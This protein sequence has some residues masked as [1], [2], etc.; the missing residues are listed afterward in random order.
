MNQAKFR[1]SII[2]SLLLLSFLIQGIWFI[3]NA[4]P[5]ADEPPHIASGWSYF[6]FWDFRMNPEHPPLI[7]YWCALPL[8]LMDLKCEKDDSWEKSQEWEFGHK[9]IFNWN[10]DKPILFYSRL[11][12]LI[13]GVFCGLLLWIFAKAVAGEKVAL[14]TLA[15]FSFNPEIISHSSFVTTDLGN[16][17]FYLLTFYGLFLILKK[18]NIKSVLI[19]IAG[20]TGGNI[21]KHSFVMVIPLIALWWLVAGYKMGK[22]HLKKAV[23]LLFITGLAV[24]LMVWVSYG[25]KYKSIPEGVEY[26]VRWE[27]FTLKGLPG[28]FINLARQTKISPEAYIYGWNDVLKKGDRPTFIWGKTHPGGVW[29][30]FPSTFILKTPLSLLILLII[31]LIFNTKKFWSQSISFQKLSGIF[32]KS[33]NKSEQKNHNELNN[34]K[35]IV[36]IPPIIWL[37]PLYYIIFFILFVRLNLGNRHILPIYPFVFIIASIGLIN[38]IKFRAGKLIGAGVFIFYFMATLNVSPNY[39]SFVNLIGGGHKNGWKD[40]ADSNYDWG[41]DLR[42]LKKWS[43]ANGNPEIKLSYFGNDDPTEIGLNYI[44]I[45]SIKPY[46]FSPLRIEE[47]I[48]KIYLKG[49]FAIS[50]N[51][52]VGMFL[53]EHHLGFNPYEYFKEKKPVAL[54]GDSIR[55][56]KEDNPTSLTLVDACM[57]SFRDRIKRNPDDGEAY[58]ML[59]ATMIYKGFE[60]D[61]VIKALFDSIEKDPKNLYNMIVLAKIFDSAGNHNLAIDLYNKLLMLEPNN[62]FA[63][64][65]LGNIYL[66]GKK[67][68]EAIKCFQKSV[69]IV[70]EYYPAWN[71]LALSAIGKQDWNLAKFAIDNAYKIEPGYYLV[72]NLY[73]QYYYGLKDYKSA[74]RYFKSVCNKNPDFALGYNNLGNVLLMDGDTTGALSAL[75]KACFLEPQNKDFQNNLLFI[76]KHLKLSNP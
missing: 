41:Q 33:K 69:D 39:L 10:K 68:D 48:S 45:P 63:W 52:L 60:N 13:W 40:L 7:K 71:N 76:E 44:L 75:E 66:E 19:L 56:Y 42:N 46:Y 59:A 29:F 8:L 43:E 64:N 72:D 55:I 6:K 26:L 37:P 70:Y 57:N 74:A 61:I 32:N 53:E 17:F 73:G 30:Y 9:F 36:S 27:K 23:I 24:Y 58:S 51:H 54:A 1:I 15:L 14:I 25:L 28:K 11:M 50:T 5:T 21:T 62:L 34:Q 18:Q 2:L 20:L 12:N 3:L 47:N 35:L 38:I 65:N 4:S 22:Y 49:Y 67:Y 31:S 16:A